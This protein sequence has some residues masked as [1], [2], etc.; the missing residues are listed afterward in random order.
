MDNLK[1]SLYMVLAM[2][3]FALEDML[4]KAATEHASIAYSVILFGLGGLVIFLGLT[5]RAGEVIFHPGLKS[6]A[7]IVRT[8]FE[9]G[10]RL[11]FALAL[12]LT[13]LST[14]SAILQATPLVVAL[15]A[16]IFFAERVGWRRWL[17]I[18]IGFVGVLLILRP[19]LDGFEA[20]SIFAVLATIGFAGRDLA[21]RASPPSMSSRQLGVYGFANI[22][23]AGLIILY[24]N[25]EGTFPEGNSLLYLLGAST[26]GVLAYLALTLSMRIGEISVV[27]SYRY[28]RLVFAMLLGILVFQETPDAL[29]LVGSAVIVLS[30]LYTA[31]RNR[32]AG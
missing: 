28:T 8:I 17:A 23:F 32:K 4:F 15:G 13:P 26:I 16:V 10:G 6:R 14:A 7:L 1:G 25:P 22:V 3:A 30:G 11:F 12:A 27:A 2:A 18:G 24:F 19:G 29:T 20:T 21:T 31:I 5:W 9:L